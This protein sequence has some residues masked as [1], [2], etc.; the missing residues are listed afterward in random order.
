MC[1]SGV[2]LDSP[3]INKHAKLNYNL[4]FEKDYFI[5]V[6]LFDNR[7]ETNSVIRKCPSGMLTLNYLQTFEHWL[8]DLVLN[9]SFWEWGQQGS[10]LQY[11]T[12]ALQ[13]FEALKPQ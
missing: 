7:N 5:S 4:Y 8:V 9:E 1:E 6:I 12:V 10:S 2:K 13:Y 3:C 11:N